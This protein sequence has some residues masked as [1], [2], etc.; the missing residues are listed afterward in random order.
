MIATP[1]AF[2]RERL[3]VWD[4]LAE[5]DAREIKL[6]AAEW[7]ASANV[8]SSPEFGPDQ[9][10]LTYDVDLDGQHASIAVGI[11]SL[12]DP[13]VE[14]LEHRD[15]VGWLPDRIAELV[16]KHTPLAIA[17]NGAG[18]ARAQVGAVQQALRDAACGGFF[19]DVVEGRLRRLIGQGPLD[20]AGEDATERPLAESWV[21]HRRQATVPIS[22]LVAVT[23]ARA[24]LPTEAEL[25]KP[26]YFY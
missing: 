22:P 20:L 24:L 9:I 23:I 3:G 13:Y 6:P 12:A 11:G 14:V 7:A 26:V 2:L 19:T 21:W 18:P 8:T 25:G 16:Q 15:G 17:C 4:P 1:E 5:D 10:I